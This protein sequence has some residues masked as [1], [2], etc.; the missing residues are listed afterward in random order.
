MNEWNTRK[1]FDNF[2]FR[3]PNRELK[4]LEEKKKGGKRKEIELKLGGN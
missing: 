4:S 1:K 2:N 3:C